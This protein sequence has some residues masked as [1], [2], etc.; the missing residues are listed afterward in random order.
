M[1][2]VRTRFIPNTFRATCLAARRT[3]KQ[4]YRDHISEGRGYRNSAKTDVALIAWPPGDDRGLEEA[5]A[6]RSTNA[7]VLNVSVVANRRTPAP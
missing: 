2:A 3:R 6:F 4:L 5:A 7:R 1:Y